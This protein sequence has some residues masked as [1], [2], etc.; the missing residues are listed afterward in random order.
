MST[1]RGLVWPVPAVSHSPPE[2]QITGEVSLLGLCWKTDWSFP[3]GDYLPQTCAG[4]TFTALATRPGFKIS[5]HSLQFSSHS[6]Q[7][8]TIAALGLGG[9]NTAQQR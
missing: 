2:M 9:C 6:V 7:S 1:G 3:A 5:H 4:R 8:L